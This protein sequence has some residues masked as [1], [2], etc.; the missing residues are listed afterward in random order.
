[1][2]SDPKIWHLARLLV[3]K[4]GNEALAVM[5]ERALWRLTVQDYRLAIL[6][7]RVAE[8]VHTLRP[9][10]TPKRS[11]WYAQ[12]PLKEL[13]NDPLMEVVVKGD[14]DRRREVH[15]TLLDAKRKIRG[16]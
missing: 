5:T 6:W 8:A 3:D 9:D 4:H 14:E 11:V 12:A 1:M 2:R 7:M 16:D 10:A 15:E 13:M